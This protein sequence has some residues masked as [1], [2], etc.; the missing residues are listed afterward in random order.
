M[1]GDRHEPIIAAIVMRRVEALETERGW[2]A[3]QGI[4]RQDKKARSIAEIY[5]IYLH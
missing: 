5:Y 3:R 2:K 1:I 4:T